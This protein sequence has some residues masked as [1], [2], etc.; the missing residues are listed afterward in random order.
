MITRLNF[1]SRKDIEPSLISSR[2]ENLNAQR[3][4]HISWNL[5]LYAFDTNFVMYVDVFDTKSTRTLR[6]A[7]GRIEAGIG[8]RDLD[9]SHFPNIDSVR[10]RFKVVSMESSGRAKIVAS[11]DRVAPSLPPEIST[12]FSMLSIEEKDGLAVPWEMKFESGEPVLWISSE[13]NL[14]SQLRNTSTA[15]W[16][17]PTIMH[18]IARQIFVWLCTAASESPSNIVSQWEDVFIGHGSSK[19]FF[20]NVEIEDNKSLPVTVENEL[21]KVLKNF[22][23]YHKLNAELSEL[24]KLEEAHQ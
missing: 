22:S 5:D 2:I 14:F 10:F 1:T 20:T 21:I 15:P 11:I 18:E 19:D 24:S 17:L 7:L 13:K 9:I 8:A 16:F 12:G 6:F 4:L 3:K 23:T